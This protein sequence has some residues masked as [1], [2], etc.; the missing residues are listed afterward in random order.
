LR[1]GQDRFNAL[2]AL[3]EVFELGTRGAGLA[4][5]GLELSYLVAQIP[6]R[7]RELFP[8]CLVRP[9]GHS[10]E[11][12]DSFAGELDFEEEPVARV[13]VRQWFLP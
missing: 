11:A 1:R 3:S 2:Q 4:S 13:S 5:L 12:L 6:Y 9:R 7:D 10:L 8:A